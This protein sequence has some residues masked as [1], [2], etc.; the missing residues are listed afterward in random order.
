ML[1][2]LGK[3]TSPHGILIGGSISAAVLFVVLWVATCAKREPE[4]PPEPSLI[5]DPLAPV[6]SLP[7]TFPKGTHLPDVRE[8]E[9]SGSVDL[10]SFSPGRELTCLDDDRVWWESDNDEGDVEDDHTIHRALEWPLR[11]LIEQVCQRGGTLE[12]HDAYRPGGVH[13]SRSLHKEGRA[14]DVTCDE[15]PLDELAKLCWAAGFDWVYYEAPRQG[16]GAHIH[17]SVRRNP[18]QSSGGLGSPSIETN[19]RSITSS[20]NE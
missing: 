14:I 19:E 20:G 10:G 4:L 16:N 5:V 12:L 13:N 7:E 3:R 6:R 2:R 18:D 11:R 9:A 15:M 8:S 17:C 1:T